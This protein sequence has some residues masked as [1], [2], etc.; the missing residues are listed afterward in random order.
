VQ[1][2]K[3]YV[4]SPIKIDHCVFDKLGK[5]QEP[6]V[7][8]HFA[9]LVARQSSVLNSI[10]INNETGLYITDDST[11]T[12]QYNLFMSNKVAI[13]IMG[14]RH[15]RKIEHNTVTANQVGISLTG[16]YPVSGGISNNNLYDN[17]VYNAKDSYSRGEGDNNLGMNWW[18]TTDTA[19]ISESIFD[20]NDG[21]AL[22]E[23]RF[24][25]IL[26]APDESAPDVPSSAQQ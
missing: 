1:I 16:Y 21:S 2:G 15:S 24:L 10:F 3:I 12:V 26:S 14:G 22:Q 6:E 18:G 8:L 7:G 23:I 4:Y 11:P 19:K 25:P 9:L 5:I 13:S 17:S 20:Y